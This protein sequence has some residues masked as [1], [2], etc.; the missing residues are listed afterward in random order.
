LG[1]I[2]EAMSGMPLQCA[3]EERILMPLE[4]HGSGYHPLR[5]VNRGAVAPTEIEPGSGRPLR[6][7]VHDEAARAVEAGGGVSGNAGIFATAA[8]LA[9]FAQLW[10]QRGAWG[11]RQVIDPRD[12]ETA[13]GAAIAGQGYR[14]GLGWHLDVSSW[15]GTQAPR[16]S[17]GHAGFTGPTLFI[18]PATQHTVIILN[19]RVYPTRQGPARMAT[20]RRIAAWLFAAA[21]NPDSKEN[22]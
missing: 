11:S 1:R 9:R 14:Q 12:V 17:A 18:S 13:L 22:P 3:I 10:L 21:A 5:R 6:G 19:N 8:E 4:M 7:V 2:V 15:M 20:H 16:G